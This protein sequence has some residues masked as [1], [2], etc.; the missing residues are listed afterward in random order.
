MACRQRAPL[1]HPLPVPA[2]VAMLAGV[3]AEAGVLGV[4]LFPIA[5]ASLLARYRLAE[6]VE[7]QQLKWLV[8][9]AALV[10]T[11]FIVLGLVT[12]VGDRLVGLGV[13]DD[14]IWFGALVSLTT[15]PIAAGI[16]ILRHRLYDIDLLINRTL[17]YGA[18]T[19]TLALAYG[20]LVVLLQ[21][22][23]RPITAG[24]DLAV[25]GS[26]LAVAALFQPVRRQIQSAVDRRFYRSKYDAERTIARFSARLRAEVDLNALQG[27]LGAAVRET[28]QPAHL[29]LWLREGPG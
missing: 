8:Y 21:Q 4:V 2:P 26:T 9:A 6:S 25:A 20:A 11:A 5:A 12:V 24:S 7:R 19:F 27:E 18:L 13:V 17:V 22:L 3:V 29:S 14:L 23:S 1:P 28:M 15:V 16:A 10:A